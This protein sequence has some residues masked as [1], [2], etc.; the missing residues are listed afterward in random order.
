MKMIDF[1]NSK[2]V[3]A[4]VG[5]SHDNTKWGAKVY[6]ALKSAGFNVYPI[7]PKHAT[8]HGDKCYNGLESLPVKPDVVI[9][10]VP[11]NI[12]EHIVKKCKELGITKV[13]M[14]PG[15]ES[16]DAITFCNDNNIEVMYNA[17]FV[18]DGLKRKFNE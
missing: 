7:N 12:T 5:V 15:S 18:V 8:V 14:Q 2:Y 6:L 3:Y 4:V 13:W 17:C 10:V 16:D 9:T 11:P 1:L